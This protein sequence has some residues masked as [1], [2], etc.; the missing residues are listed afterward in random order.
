M[1]SYVMETICR[2]GVFI[3]CAQVLVHFRPNASYEKYMKMLVSTMILLQM[4]LPVSNFFTGEGENSLA[5]RV[6]QFEEQMNESM[7]GVAFEQGEEVLGQLTL[8]E[9]RSRVANLENSDAYSEEN[10]EEVQIAPVE[11]IQVLIQEGGEADAGE[12]NTGESE[13]DDE[14]MVPQG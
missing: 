8:E 1:G 13:A 5:A 9:V 2:T 7:S 14:K 3:I 10:G 11:K 12:S 6:E 4:F